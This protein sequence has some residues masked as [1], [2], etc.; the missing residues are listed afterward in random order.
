MTP[1]IRPHEQLLIDLIPELTAARVLTNS[2]GR[3]QFAA[4]YAKAHHDSAVACWLLDLYQFQQANLAMQPPPA[5]LRL[6]C[7]ADPPLGEVDLVAWHV[8]R[9]GEAELTR[10]MLQ[11]GHG[12]L[13]IGGRMAVSVDEPKDQWLNERLQEMFPK[14]TRRPTA[15]GTVYL[16]TK[17]QPLKKIKDYACELS[18]KDGERLIH[19]RTRPG[20]FSHRQ[21]DDGARA[22]TKMELEPA[23]RILDLGC[24]SGAVG[25][26]AA[27]RMP[28][29]SVHAIDSS[30]RAI[31]ATQWAC[32]R[33]D[34]ANLTTGLDCDGSSLRPGSFDLVLANPP[35]YSNYR[36]ADLFLRI[37]QRALAGGGRLLV[38]TKTPQWY[39]E[40]LQQPWQDVGTG[41][42][43]KYVIV[44]AL[45]GSSN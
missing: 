33:N 11:V 3:G 38:V 6:V 34:A 25:V 12:Q 23:T 13:A 44:S 8:S 42:V 35:Y 4:A 10:E 28:Q 43:G 31:E 20:V 40:H 26:A 37:A 21:V 22:L 1:A 2:A 30:P 24:G 32:Q 41:Q 29:A 45:K 36:I 39:V 14:V 17:T 9:K 15:E 27:L 16:A 7:Q 5:N 18:F 19:L